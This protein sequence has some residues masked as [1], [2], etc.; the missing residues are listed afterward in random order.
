LQEK[1]T[2][3]VTFDQS[4]RL[5]KGR[6][7]DNEG[8]E[9]LV[10]K[11]VSATNWQNEIR[12]S[13]LMSNDR[14]QIQIEREFRKLGYWYVRKRQTKSEAR[15]FAGKHLRLVR[16]EQLAQAV[17]GCVLDPVLVREGKE[18]L[19]EKRLYQ[20]VFPTG[21]PLYYL[22]RYRLLREVNY[23]AY[24]S[25]ERSYA[26]WLVLHFAW[27]R[28]APLVRSR[29]A[30]ETFRN[31]SEKNVAPMD[32]LSMAI[33]KVFSASRAFYRAKRGHGES[34]LDVST[35]FYRRNL[36]RQFES[37]WSGQKNNA[38]AGFNKFWKRFRDGLAEEA[39]R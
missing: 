21:D 28:L 10:S 39:A 34:A 25:R 23:R 22:V 6:N 18:R 37:F 27:T 3:H 38:R 11:I 4:P 26:K 20:Q 2:H 14:R 36:D 29:T 15:R 32:D 7:T 30:A 33:A 13:D 5:I 8:F 12:P 19:F 17:A 1:S 35:F 16:K 24:G 9:S 31:A